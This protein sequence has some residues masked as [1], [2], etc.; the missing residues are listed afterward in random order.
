[1]DGRR[2]CTYCGLVTSDRDLGE[3]SNSQLAGAEGPLAFRSLGRG[4]GVAADL[5][6]S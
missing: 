5:Q 3:P 6:A 1:M 2:E 4:A